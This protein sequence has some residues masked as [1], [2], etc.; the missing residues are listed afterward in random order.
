MTEQREC[1]V[2][3]EIGDRKLIIKSGKLA[4]QASGSVWVQYGDTVV[5]VAATT[6]PSLRDIDWFPLFMDYREKQYAAG[7][8][9]RGFF[10]REGR[11]TD[12][13]I[14][15]MRL[16][17]RPL[18]PLFPK[19]YGEEVQVQAI[20][21]SFDQE[22]ESDILAMIGASASVSVS[23]IPFNGPVGTVRLGR[24]NGELIVNPTLTQLA[25]SDFEIVMS[26]VG[27]TVNMIEV[28]AKV[29]SDDDL[30]EALTAGSK[31]IAEITEM[32]RELMKMV[33]VEKEWTPPEVD[34]APAEAVA[35]FADEL[36]QCLTVEGKQA[37]NQ[38]I[39]DLKQRVL[40]EL[41][42][43]DVEEPPLERKAV[44]TAFGE[45]KERIIRQRILEGIR[46]DGRGL[47]EIRPITCEVGLMPRT[48][49]SALFTRGETQALV[50]TT[51]GT[52]DD[53]QIIDGLAPEYRKR[54]MLQYNFPP[55]SVGEVKPI[56]GPSR[57]DIGHGSLAEKCLECIMPPVED[58]AYTVL[59]VSE[60]L[61][62]NGSSS[63]A[64]VCGSTLALMDAGIPIADPVAGISIGLVEEGDRRALLTDIQGAEDHYGDMDFKVA[65]TQH[66]IT[67]IQLDLKIGGVTLDV[68]REGLKQA[69]E[70]R[71]ELLKTMLSVLSAPRDHISEYAPRLLFVKIDPDKIGKLIG[72][73]GKTVKGI[74]E[75]TGARIEIDDDGQ[76]MISCLEAAGAEAAK[77]RVEAVTGNVEVGTIYTGKIVSIKDF[78]VFVELPCMQDGM[79]HISELADTY[80]KKVEDVVKLGDEIRVKVIQVDPQGRIKL[81]R[82]IAFMAGVVPNSTATPSCP[83]TFRML[84]F[85]S[86]EM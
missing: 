35:R 3:R 26:G 85:A 10:K 60:I 44:A 82:K 79:C 40:D 83:V 11:P 72:P 13:E 43:E 58:F 19:G 70:A 31:V 42:P 30:M 52:Y 67:G 20:V 54:F 9:P 55:F 86:S 71:L 41:S 28:G 12:K 36:T 81:S 29:L 48:H 45:M 78:G 75:E 17:D 15:A 65:G 34:P 37:Q 7:K 6:A 21:L 56:R 77:E 25:D 14:L 51:L 66:G 49:G 53:Q 27:D 32:Q 18:R 24:V 63:M 47:T 23:K 73:G 2:E 38:A 84:S 50:A 39:D 74:Q 68:L 22:N 80:V 5:L 16:M 62:S 8:V 64:T 4:K 69:H 46:P 33:G 59:A 61:E 57:R 1:V 76:V